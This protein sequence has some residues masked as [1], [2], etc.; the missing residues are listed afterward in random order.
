MQAAV[1][2]PG[3]GDGGCERE[4]VDAEGDF[5]GAEGEAGAQVGAVDGGGVAAAEVAFEAVGLD[6]GVG[7][8]PAEGV[9][10]GEVVDGGVAGEEVGGLA[11]GWVF[12]EVAEI[13][14]LV[15]EGEA[16][17]G[18]REVEG[19]L[20]A[21]EGVVVASVGWEGRASIDHVG[22]VACCDCLCRGN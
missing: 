4:G 16:E 21:A 20:S 5:A 15:C 17:A 22:G 2:E 18:G 6:G 11:A 3:H 1:E 9:A 19:A 7:E 12:G 8:F 10:G 14:E 13:E